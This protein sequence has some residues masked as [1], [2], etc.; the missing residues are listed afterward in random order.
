MRKVRFIWLTRFIKR[1]KQALEQRSA[2]GQVDDPISDSKLEKDLEAQEILKTR[3]VEKYRQRTLRRAQK[4]KAHLLVHTNQKTVLWSLGV[5]SITFLI[6]S[7][8]IYWRLY[9]A[10]D[11]SVFM[12]NITRFVPLPV[13]RVGSTW[14][15]YEDYL[16]QLHRQI[17]YFE[18]QQQVDFN[19]STTQATISLQE[20]KQQA[21]QRV[22]T[23]TYIQ[24]LADQYQLT[25]TE[26]EID[27][28]LE[29]LRRQ[30]KLASDP[31]EIEGILD[32]FWDWS[33]ADYRQVVAENLLQKK[34]VRVMDVILKNN[35]LQRMKDIEVRL[36][37]GAS[38][39]ELAEEFSENP[40]T[41]LNA[42]IHDFFF[43][44]EDRHEDPIVLEAA[45]QTP[46]GQISDIIDTGERLEILK[47]LSNEGEGLRR[48]AHIRIF[49]APLTEVLQAIRQKEPVTIYIDGI[50]YSSQY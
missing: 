16:K 20:L 38:F 22:I 14:I 40:Q 30:N 49:Y 39:S 31:E 3:A 13:A 6:L 5:I 19:D 11:Y 17:H 50:D 35:A 43:D 7:G 48:V 32:D 46:I 23:A 28:E 15:A 9:H 21:L 25:V 37:N 4:L 10:Q 41:A 1:R 47:I 29:R 42:G 8:I 2:G 45:F 18:I 26:Q 44:L 12:Y 24:K 34:V 27:E 33:T 36:K